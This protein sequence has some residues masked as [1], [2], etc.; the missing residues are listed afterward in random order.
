M[1]KKTTHTGLRLVRPTASKANLQRG[2]SDRVQKAIKLQHID[3][4]PYQ[5]RRYFDED[6]LKELAASIQR[7]GLI[8]PIVVRPIRK[9]YELIAGERR[10]RAI[11]EYTELKTIQAQVVHVD[12]L[13]ARRIS[14]AE[15]MQ[16]EDLSAIE[17]I[18]AIVEIVDAELIQDKQYAG[19]GKTPAG[20]VKTL[21]GKLD[22]VRRTQERGSRISNQ[23]KSLSHKFMGQIEQ[24]F[25]RLPKPVGWRSFYNNS[26]PILMDICQ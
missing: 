26:L 3:P 16:R 12:D 14:A 11:R 21:L 25:T 17:T 1:P 23:S 8:E 7:E 5:R 19:M 13:Q 22:S 2:K 18:E 10:L 6:K 9:R 15:N 24:I 4:S 20:R